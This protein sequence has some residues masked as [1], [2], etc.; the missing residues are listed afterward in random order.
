MLYPAIFP[1]GSYFSSC[2]RQR[3]QRQ[4]QRCRY[5]RPRRRC[6]RHQRPHQRRY[7]PGWLGNLLCARRC[8]AASDAPAVTAR[9]RRGGRGNC[10]LKKSPSSHRPPVPSS[11]PPPLLTSSR[12]LRSSVCLV[13]LFCFWAGE[14]IT[15]A[16]ILAQAAEV[17]RC[18][19]TWHGA[20][21]D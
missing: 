21:R 9:A 13:S 5:A 15:E 17:A 11:S 8:R 2:R 18:A 4:H 14:E 20:G 10:A 7:R 12:S 1:F 19:S 3:C 6:H 16:A